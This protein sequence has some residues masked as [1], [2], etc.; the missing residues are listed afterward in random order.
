MGIMTRLL[1]DDRGADLV[2]YAMLVG[3]LALATIASID[4]VG[5][6]IKGLW[7]ILDSRIKSV[8]LP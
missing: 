1:R 8:P 5:A 7:E 3:L 2:E 6:Q 4:G